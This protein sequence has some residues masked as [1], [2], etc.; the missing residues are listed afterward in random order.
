MRCSYIPGRVPDNVQPESPLFK[1]P[2]DVKIRAKEIN[3]GRLAMCSILG[4]WANTACVV[5]DS[6]E[7]PGGVIGLDSL[8]DDC[9]QRPPR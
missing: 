5:Y 2:G 6:L 8:E 4:I 9:P 7:R 3:N 1:V